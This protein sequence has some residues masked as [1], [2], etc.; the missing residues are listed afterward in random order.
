MSKSTCNPFSWKI[1]IALVFLQA[2]LFA[3][4]I[5]GTITLMNDS[6]YIL[7]ATVYTRSGEYLGQVTLQPGEQKNFTTNLSSTNLNR[8]GHSDVSITP[9]RIVW[10]C[11]GGGVYSMAR[12]G[13]VGSFVRASECPGALFCSPPENKKPEE[14]PLLKPGKK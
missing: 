11:P 1:L 4:T 7:T 13:S 6:P 3:T 10:Q 14:G 12:D 8:P 9:Y 5:P 2:S